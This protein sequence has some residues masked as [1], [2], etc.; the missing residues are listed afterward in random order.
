MEMANYII[1]IFKTNMPVIMSWGYNSPVALEN[2]LRFSVNGFKHKGNVAVIY[3]EGLD[4]FNIEI[5]TFKNE[6]IDTINGVY[7][8]QLIEVIDN[9]VELVENYDQTVKDEY[10]SNNEIKTV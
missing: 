2:G 5:L 6:V 3:D 1:S 7:F 4:L 9:R 8:D 10:S